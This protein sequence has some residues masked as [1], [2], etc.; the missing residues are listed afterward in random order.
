MFLSADCSLSSPL[1]TSSDANTLLKD[2]TNI[3]SDVIVGDPTCTGGCTLSSLQIAAD[4]VVEISGSLV[5]RCCD[6]LTFI[7]GWNALETIRG[8]LIIEANMEVLAVVN[9]FIAL[10]RLDGSLIIRQNGALTS[11]RAAF[12]VLERIGGYI[13]IERNRKLTD[14]SGLATLSV[15]EGNQL[16]GGSALSVLFNPALED[17]AWLT[18]LTNIENGVV[19]IEGNT[20]LCYAGY[21]QWGT[22]GSFFGRS[23]VQGEDQGIDW[24]TLIHSSANWE[25]MWTD[26]NIPSLVVKDNAAS[27]TCGT[28]YVSGLKSAYVR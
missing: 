23:G 28:L 8:S 7:G 9:A 26:M 18:R 11:V 13:N 3:T 24:R 21:P 20:G 4:S 10:T 12:S 16:M 2:C 1:L 17:M 14:V 15:I 6:G 27:E 25:Y 19:H 22:F 5:I